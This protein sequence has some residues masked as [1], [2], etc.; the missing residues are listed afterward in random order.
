MR[1]NSNNNF[2]KYWPD[3][4]KIIKIYKFCK[5]KILAKRTGKFM[6]PTRGSTEALLRGAN[7]NIYVSTSPP[8]STSTPTTLWIHDSLVF[9]TIHFFCF[10]FSCYI[11]FWIL[12]VSYYKIAKLQ[13]LL[14]SENPDLI[15]LRLQLLL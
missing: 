13:P 3:F 8:K 11:F 2:I 6:P 15:I 12:L 7:R 10:F 4:H 1:K 9:K 5:K 14:H